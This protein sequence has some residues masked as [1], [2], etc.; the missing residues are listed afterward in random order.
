MKYRK[1][2]ITTIA[3]ALEA[4]QSNGVKVIQASGDGTDMYD[5]T[6][7]AYEADE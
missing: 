7:N 5:T 3:S 2:E 4:V 1:P 6:P